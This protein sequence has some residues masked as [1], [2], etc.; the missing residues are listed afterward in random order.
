M[1]FKGIGASGGMALA[2]AFV[3]Q[4]VPGITAEVATIDPSQAESELRRFRQAVDKAAGQLEAIAE[5]AR[6]AGD[7]DRAGIIDAQCMMLTDPAV[8]EGVE[9]KILEQLLPA[10]RAVAETIEEQAE[11]LAGLDDPYLRERAADVRD[12]GGRLAFILLGVQ[13]QDLSVLAEAVILAGREIT[14]SQMAS[15]AADKVKGIVAETGG[16][17]SHTAILAKNMGIPAVLGCAGVLSAIGDGDLLAVDGDRG[18]VEVRL[19][20]ARVDELQRE[21]ANRQTG[22]DALQALVGRPTRT[23]DGFAVELAANIMG[24][25]GAARAL[26]AGADGIGLYRTEFLFMDRNSPPGEDEQYEAYAKVLKLMDGKPVI[27]RTMDIGGD[28]AI[29]YLRLPR[30]ENPFLGYRAIRICLADR[31]LFMTQLRA[32][33]R[34]GVHGHALIM[35]PMIAVPEELQAANAML[36]AAKESLHAD[37]LPFDGNLQAGIMVEIP[38]AAAAADLLI[39]DAAFFSIGTNDLTQYTL[40]VDRLNEKVSGLYDSFQPGVLR[41]IRQ[42][43]E[44]ANHAGGGK[45]AGMCGEMASDPLAT[46]LLLGMGMTEFSVNPSALLT[47]KKI[48]TSVELAYAREVAAQAMKLHSAVQVR[49]Y[50]AAAMPLELRAYLK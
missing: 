35:Y 24:P 37:G 28:K 19:E 3:I 39:G 20:A 12:V 49:S 17:T 36:Q 14:A 13:E 7:S 6:Q 34:A 50:L 33:L 43:I 5:K 8:E 1:E 2:R 18:R 47:I 9:T 45:F 21:I 15:L 22:E 10:V 23:L 16:V 38:A 42:V 41:L 11:I 46:L 25:E 31:A 30:E 40:A 26:K 48:I 32:I 27:I 44:T 29:A 4:P